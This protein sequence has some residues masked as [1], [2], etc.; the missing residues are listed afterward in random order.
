[1]ISTNEFIFSNLIDVVFIVLGII[2]YIKLKNS[3][4]LLSK[5]NKESKEKNKTKKIDFD[6]AEKIKKFLDGIIK[7]KFEYYLTVE[8][9]PAYKTS[10]KLDKKDIEDLKNNFFVDVSYLINK[11]VKNSIKKYFN[12]DAIKI[13]IIEKFYIYLNKVDISYFDELNIDEKDVKKLIRD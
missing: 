11:D 9:L 2:F 4:N 7:D 6:E 10:K 1:M 13:Y 3:I 8:I 12:T 5:E